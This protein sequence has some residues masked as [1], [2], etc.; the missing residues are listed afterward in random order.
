MPH[1]APGTDTRTTHAPL[2]GGADSFPPT[3]PIDMTPYLAP[4]TP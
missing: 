2:H 3:Q 4:G 1:L